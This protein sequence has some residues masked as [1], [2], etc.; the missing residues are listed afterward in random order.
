MHGFFD[1][2][3]QK[4][5]QEKFGVLLDISEAVET[6]DKAFIGKKF[7]YKTGDEYS[8]YTHYEEIS[9][10]N[11][12]RP[13]TKES[14]YNSLVYGIHTLSGQMDKWE[15]ETSGIEETEYDTVKPFY[16]PFAYNEFHTSPYLEPVFFFGMDCV[17]L[18][19]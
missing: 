11:F 8:G 3:L 16:N 14:L 17:D 10:H 7:L 4:Y 6:T 9:L 5:L 18:L 13:D 19:N 1:L 15:I 2:Q 12:V